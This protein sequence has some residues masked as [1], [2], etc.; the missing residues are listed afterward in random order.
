MGEIEKIASRQPI[1]SKNFTVRFE[2]VVHQ[3]LAHLENTSQVWT[4]MTISNMFI[5]LNW[6]I[7]NVIIIEST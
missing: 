4:I 2:L 7:H 5:T 3:E 1:V 6:G